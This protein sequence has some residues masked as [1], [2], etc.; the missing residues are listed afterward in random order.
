[1]SWKLGLTSFMNTQIILVKNFTK[2][3]ALCPLNLKFGG[4]HTFAANLLLRTW[5]KLLAHFVLCF[6]ASQN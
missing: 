4:K 3:V 2:V 1:M 5:Q 6:I